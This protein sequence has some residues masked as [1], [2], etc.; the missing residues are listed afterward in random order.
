MFAKFKAKVAAYRTGALS[1]ESLMASLQSYLGAMS[2]ADAVQL[3][4]EMKNLIWFVD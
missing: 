2:H 4:E 1:E 3:A